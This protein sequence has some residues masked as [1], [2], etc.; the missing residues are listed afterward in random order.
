LAELAQPVIYHVAA[1]VVSHQD[2]QSAAQLLAAV[3]EV[4]VRPGT[5]VQKNQLLVRL[6]CQHYRLRQQELQ[7][8][9]RSIDA[10]RNLA[11]RQLQRAQR[12]VE[13]GALS[14]SQLDERRSDLALQQARSQVLDARLAQV[15][16]DI[17]H[18]SIRAPFTG[19]V[20]QLSASAGELYNPGQGLL[21]LQSLQ[22]LE[23]TASINVQQAA[24]LQQAQAIWFVFNQQRYPIRLRAQSPR[25]S[26]TSN[27]Q[28]WYWHL[29]SNHADLLG[30]RGQVFWRSPAK[31]PADVLV[32]RQGQWGVFV[33]KQNQAFFQPLPNARGG[34]PA[35]PHDLADTAQI[36]VQ[37]QQGLADGAEVTKRAIPLAD[38]SGR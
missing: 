11:A 34:Y 33:L 2:S 26:Q 25:R 3:Q 10:Q 23:V 28:Q 38:N 35:L 21:Q 24:D 27:S 12:L 13:R 36:I 19:V 9:L 29:A 8:E 17:D 31:I 7:G 6:D 5:V 1:E 30:A 20:H 37:G 16:R 22:D 15:K 14:Q 32:Q 18:C 4:L